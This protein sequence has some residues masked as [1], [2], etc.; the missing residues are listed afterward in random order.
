MPQLARVYGL[1]EI[2]QNLRDLGARVPPIVGAG[3]EAG[4][5][6]VLDAARS[7]AAPL[8]QTLAASLGLKQR[9]YK[10]TGV[11]AT[12]VGP[13]KGHKDPATG[14]NPVSTAHLIEDGTKPH[15]MPANVEPLKF[16]HGA[17]SFKH[18]VTHPGTPASPWLR[19]AWD[20]HRGDAVAVLRRELEDRLIRRQM[21]VARKEFNVKLVKP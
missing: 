18:I 13:T 14:H 21:K 2:I 4:M 20:A 1:E 8:S 3:S 12:I 17:V 16:K 5:T 9:V 7:N 15:A 19:P 6:L 11:I 10:S